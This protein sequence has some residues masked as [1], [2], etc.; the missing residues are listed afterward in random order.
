ML[1]P[2][3]GDGG[4]CSGTC[5][6]ALCCGSPGT[7]GSDDSQCCHGACNGTKCCLDTGMACST[8]FECCSGVCGMVGGLCL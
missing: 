8:S 5:V 7:T 3:T 1:S 6:N 2:C 4:C